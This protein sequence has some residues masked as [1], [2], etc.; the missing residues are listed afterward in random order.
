MVRVGSF[1][2]YL[3]SDHLGTLRTTSTGGGA[4]GAIRTF[5]AFGE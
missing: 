5:T 1:S 3:H 4:G 2:E